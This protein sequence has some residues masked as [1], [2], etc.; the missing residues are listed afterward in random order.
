MGK[1]LFKML[2]AVFYFEQVFVFCRLINQ[3]VLEWF[4]HIK[5]ILKSRSTNLF[6]RNHP[7]CVFEKVGR[8]PITVTLSNWQKQP[9]EV[10]H[11][12]SCFQIFAIITRKHLCFSLFFIKLQTF[13]PAT[14]L[15]RDSNTGV[16]LLWDFCKTPN[17]KNICLLLLLNWLY[18]VIVWNFVSE[19]SL[20]KPSWLSNITKIPVTFKPDL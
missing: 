12:K 6:S 11:K 18:E 1:N 2:N 9:P 7:Y 17:L 13:R 4:L 19:Q 8:C 15:K 10:F 3:N 5:N 14:L 20:S 16:F